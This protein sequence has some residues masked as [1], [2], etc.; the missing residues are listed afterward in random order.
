GHLATTSRADER[1]LRTRCSNI[2]TPQ[3]ARPEMPAARGVA[4]GLLAHPCVQQPPTKWPKPSFPP[5]KRRRRLWGRVLDHLDGILHH[6]LEGGVLL[7]VSLVGLVAQ[8]LLQS[9]QRGTGPLA[10]PRQG[11]GCGLPL[12]LIKVPVR[13]H[14]EEIR[15]HRRC[16]VPHPLEGG[17]DGHS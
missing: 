12:I 4:P 15:H 6:P 10:D 13:D 5:T 8:H 11:R 9:G 3:V 16:L 14:L 7:K 1:T 2:L 17:E